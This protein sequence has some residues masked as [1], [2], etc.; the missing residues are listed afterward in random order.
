MPIRG[1][2]Y[3]IGATD[4]KG[5]PSGASLADFRGLA[6]RPGAIEKM[7]VNRFWSFTLT[8][9]AG[10]AERAYAQTLSADAFEVLGAQAM[11]GRTFLPE[12]YRPGAPRVCVIA[13]RL[14]QRRYSSTNDIIGR[15]IELDGERYTIVGVMPAQFQFPLN[16]Y[17][18]WVPWIFS[19]AELAA[20]RDHGLIIYARLRRGAALP[21]AQAE[22]DSFAG[23]MAAQFPDT[24]KN[25][26][27]QIGPAKLNAGD[28]YR[29]QMLVLLGAT[30]FVLLIACL[31]VANLLLARAA[32]RRREIA[33]RIALG[34]GR[35]RIVRQLLAESSLLAVMGGAGGLAAGWWSSRAL[36]AAFPVRT[37]KPAVESARNRHDGFSVR[38]GGDGGDG[39]RVRARA[40]FTVVPTELARHI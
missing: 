5:S 26:H 24:E 20:R 17:S 34:A 11:R 14:W 30:G 10:D 15:Q 29:A 32:A 40:G 35:W 4:A 19:D 16:V 36:I 39:S 21:Q 1:I 27:P 33:M 8:D 18:L 28:Q 13:Y 7:S 37:V 25:W 2:L 22:L 6:E 12:D 3:E 23:A 38:T 31:N 9:S